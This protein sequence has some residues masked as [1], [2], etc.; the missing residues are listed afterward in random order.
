MKTVI[1]CQTDDIAA[2]SFAAVE[3][4][5]RGLDVIGVGND[6]VEAAKEYWQTAIKE[7][8]YTVPWRGSVFLDTYA[9]GG[10]ILDM[11]ERII[12]GT[13][14]ENAVVAPAIVGGLYNWEELWPD[15]METDFSA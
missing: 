9:Y 4:A 3:A 15:L 12:A 13:Q 10:L 1:F 8:N 7:E 6:C 14:E 2:S 5:G 11:A